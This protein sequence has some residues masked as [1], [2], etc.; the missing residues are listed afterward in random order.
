MFLMVKVLTSLLEAKEKK[1]RQYYINDTQ[2]RIKPFEALFSTRQ[3]SRKKLDKLFGEWVCVF[4]I[5]FAIIY[6]LLF[7]TPKI[8]INDIIQIIIASLF[9]IFY[10]IWVLIRRK[11]LKE[12][13]EKL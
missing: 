10:T 3:A 5:L 6:P 9:G 2:Q 8:Q 11:K 13:L 4:G 12:K 1:S 7:K